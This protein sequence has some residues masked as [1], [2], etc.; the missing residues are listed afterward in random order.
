MAVLGTTYPTLLDVARILDP[1]GNISA[2]AEVLNHHNEVLDDIIWKE[3]NL[4]TGHQVTLRAFI[5]TPTFRLFN[6][7]IAP[8][9]TTTRQLTET[10]AML[11]NYSTIDKDLAMLNGNTA[12]FRASQDV[13]IMEGMNQGFCSSLVYGDTSVD[14]E[15]FIGLA[16]RYYS[17]SASVVTGGQVIKAGGVGADNTSIYLVGWGPRTVYGVYPKGTMGGL[18]M[19]DLGEQTIY[20]ASGNP[21]QAFRT[22]Y[23]WKCGLAIE[24]WRYVV[25]IA[26]I[27]ISDLETAGDTSDTS[28]NLL[29]HMSVA[30]DKLFTLTGVNPVFYANQRV[31]AMLRVKFFSKTNAL[32]TLE[33]IK[34]A[35]G[36]TR[37][38]LRF[39]GFPIRRLDEITVAESLVP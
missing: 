26:N 5:P 30:L 4:P 22:Y 28:A 38:T 24:D 31:R 27:D 8:V 9:K 3:G 7:G 11:A 36:I 10:C 1:Q 19:R 18:E 16:P 2:V 35:S 29:K 14:P 25:R 6:Q 15:K 23:Q 33:D 34:G 17:S 32:L 13:G 12:E 37:P 39:Q 21:F 20:D